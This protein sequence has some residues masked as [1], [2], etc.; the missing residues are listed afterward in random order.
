MTWDLRGTDHRTTPNT[1]DFVAQAGHNGH[2]N[3]LYRIPVNMDLIT[4]IAAQEKK[5]GGDL[6][7]RTAK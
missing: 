6:I 7:L 2:V 5:T 4:R 3:D 1:G